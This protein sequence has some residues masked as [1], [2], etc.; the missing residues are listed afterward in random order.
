[1]AMVV[2]Y[3]TNGTKSSVWARQ[4]PVVSSA[5]SHGVQASAVRGATPKEFDKIQMFNLN[6]NR[7]LPM[8]EWV[9]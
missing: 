9:E 3:Q 8:T 4:L 2:W 5:T 7:T 6:S 1:R